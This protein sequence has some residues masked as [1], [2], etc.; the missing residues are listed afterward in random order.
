ML[1]IIVTVFVSL[2]TCSWPEGI[3]CNASWLKLF[4]HAQHTHWHTILGNSVCYREREGETG[5]DLCTVLGIWLTRAHHSGWKTSLASCSVVDWC[6]EYEGWHFYSSE[7][8][9]AWT[10][11][12]T[13]HVNTLHYLNVNTHRTRYATLMWTHTH[14]M[15]THYLRQKCSPSVDVHHQVKPT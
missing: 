6:W 3:Y 2:F 4:C 10:Y 9:T 11:T 1:T 14:T 13:H 8:C 7:G 5:L 12:Y 15:W